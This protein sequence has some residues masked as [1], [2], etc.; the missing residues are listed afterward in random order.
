MTHKNPCNASRHKR[1]TN[2]LHPNIEKCNWI[3]PYWLFLDLRI[4]SYINNPPSKR[5]WNIKIKHK[6]QMRLNLQCRGCRLPLF[7][8]WVCCRLCI[9]VPSTL[10]MNYVT[11]PQS[12]C[13]WRSES[14]ATTWENCMP[15]PSSSGNTFLSYGFPVTSMTHQQQL[16]LPS[17]SKEDWPLVFWSGFTSESK[18]NLDVIFCKCLSASFLYMKKV[19]A[20]SVM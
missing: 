3:F 2:L 1:P 13:L 5:R 15:W 19:M 10:I 17:L 18:P 9:L 6:F 20:M 12:P 4:N 11:G 8:L 14:T 16:A 7:I